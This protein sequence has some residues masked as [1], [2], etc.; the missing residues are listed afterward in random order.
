MIAYILNVVLFQLLFLLVYEVMLKKETF[1]SYNRW[2]LLATSV[3]SLLL[4]LVKIE[5]FAF[6]IPA[7][8]L[9]G[10]STIWLPEVLIGEAPAAASTSINTEAEILKVNWWLVT[11]GTGVAASLF[12]FFRKYQ[13]LSRLFRFK[14]LTAE[15]E[16]RI[17]E[18]PNS[19]LACTFYRTVFIGDKLTETER[20]NILSHELVHVKEGHSLDLIFFEVLKVVFWFNPL[21][22][23][24]QIKIAAVHEFIADAAVVETSGRRSYYEQLLNSAFNTKN[25]SFINQFFNHSLIKKRIVML[26]KSRS[27][28][29]S[30]AR[31]FI[32]FPIILAMLTIVACSVEKL[33]AEAEITKSEERAIFIKVADFKNQ[34][35]EEKERIAK[36]LE[37]MSTNSN[38]DQVHITDGKKSMIMAKDPSTGRPQIVIENIEGGIK[39]ERRI[40]P[41]YKDDALPFAIIEE[42]PVFSGCEALP[43][44]E[45]R[46]KCM[47]EKVSEFVARNFNT[48]LGKE[49]G[50]K[51]VNRVIAVFKISSDGDITDVRARAPHPALEAEAI[52]VISS[53]PQMTPGKHEG[54]NVA[55]SY[56]L[57]IVFQVA[58]SEEQKQGQ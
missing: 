8:A 12:L 35:A 18:I 31:Y 49:L 26:Q 9:P 44:N 17:I 28:S 56:S 33:P 21:V 1:F 4:P 22:Y 47:A 36:A 14:T 19:T 53:L 23:I 57:P 40:N 30:K 51:G 46:K 39:T 52:R 7:E 15:G 48:G 45:E 5:A 42:V 34:T 55:V 11:Y 50:L 37:G 16:V 38:Y 25:I 6:F 43:T 54:N 58:E 32:V 20:Q 3:I 2:Y 29:I 13:N 10:I 41:D 24:Y 27:K